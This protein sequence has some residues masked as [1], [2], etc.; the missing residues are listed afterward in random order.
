MAPLAWTIAL[1]IFS[2][3]CLYTAL[4]SSIQL[5]TDT[6]LI[7]NDRWYGSTPYNKFTSLERHFHR[8]I[9]NQLITAGAI[10]LGSLTVYAFQL[11]ERYVHIL[12]QQKPSAAR[13]LPHILQSS[14][15]TGQGLNR[16]LSPLLQF[17]IV[18]VAGSIAASLAL[19]MHLVPWTVVSPIHKTLTNQLRPIFY[20]AP[21]TNFPQVPTADL[22]SAV[23]RSI[24][25]RAA[26]AAGTTDLP[27]V[28]QLHRFKDHNIRI[29][30]TIY[31]NASTLGVGISLSSL[32]RSPDFEVMA[33]GFAFIS[34]NAT[35]VGTHAV[36][37]CK[38]MT[39]DWTWQTA[40]YE[41]IFE[42]KD[43]RRSPA[44]SVVRYHQEDNIA[45]STW[46]EGWNRLDPSDMAV[47]LRQMFAI[48]RCNESNCYNSPPSSLEAL[49]VECNY[50]GHDRLQSV[51]LSG[52]NEPIQFGEDKGIIADLRREDLAP[53]ATAISLLMG[54]ETS[55]WGG[56]GNILIEG[57][58]QSG[59]F[60][61]SNAGDKRTADFVRLLENVL[62]DTVQT[63]FT[64]LRQES[65]IWRLPF[66]SEETE[67]TITVVVLRVG[68][69][70][71]IWVT[72]IASLLT[73]PLVS[74]V[75]LTIAWY[76]VYHTLERLELV[77]DFEDSAL[78]DGDDDTFLPQL[79]SKGEK[80]SPSYSIADEKS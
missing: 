63:Y 34:L 77:A 45:M 38:D 46:L 74:L 29:G 15:A 30:D 6:V 4:Q 3:I 44:V 52:P 42:S 59:Y 64:L 68:G 50:T 16:G 27:S 8:D 32:R 61:Q 75:R 24:Y 33:P 37:K 35:V 54:R 69:R 31:P 10:L 65:E 57:L 12:V 36:A 28:R 73:L 60:L 55:K 70:G 9:W 62:T 14:H 48:I 19:G 2:L 71:W 7:W 26:G 18:T 79:L 21:D 47:P 51:T 1:N 25:L 13:V 78:S 67:G 17:A 40:R 56:D 80:F 39:S 76:H 49:V 22:I 53:A 58:T 23:Y 20:D 43:V 5:K 41:V 72:I 11:H 66:R